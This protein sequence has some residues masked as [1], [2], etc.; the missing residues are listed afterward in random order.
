MDELSILYVTFPNKEEALKVSEIVVR[1][2]LAACANAMPNVASTFFW[3]GQINRSDE[4]VL[5]IKTMPRA[6]VRLVTRVREL[7]TYEVPCLL[8]T[9]FRSHNLDYYSWADE[10]VIR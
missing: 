10:S 5:L 6:I 7:H 8:E 1:E 2:R 9:R 3:Q 4:V